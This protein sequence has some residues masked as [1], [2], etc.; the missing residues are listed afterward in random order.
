MKKFFLIVFIVIP[1]V[2]AVL[3]S[4]L[5]SPFTKSYVNEHGHELIGRKI[6]VDGV[7]I[8]V[9]TGN[10]AL[11]DVTIFEAN[12]DS[13][14][15]NAESM[16]VNLSMIDLLQ[17]KIH[18]EALNVNNPKMNIVQRDTTFNFDDMLQFFAEGGE[19]SSDEYVIDKFKL[20]G[21]EV[22]YLDKTEPSVPFPYKLHKLKVTA[23][24]FST[25]GHNHLELSSRLGEFG[26]MKAEYD[27]KITESDNCSLNFELKE[28]DLTDFTPL[29]LQMF[30]REV[31]DGKLNLESQ[32]T[33]VNGKIDGSNHVQIISPKVEKVKGLAF[34]PEYRNIPLKS[35]LYIMTDKNGVCDIDL[36]VSGT[37]DDPKFTYKRALMKMFGKAT[38]KVFTSPFSKIGKN[39]E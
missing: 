20:K 10:V 17:K 37:K 11:K 32:I 30:G 24:D 28:L 5:V 22:N 16:D 34:R 27:G 18:L 9:F 35:V 8:N 2:F 31:L 6:N 38:L 14:F 21:G 26:E 4:L 36:P 23:K 29:F 13:V 12:G 19:E 15:I 33:I 1:V 3:V 25:N 7:S 39:D